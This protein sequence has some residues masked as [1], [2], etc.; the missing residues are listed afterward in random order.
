MFI[1]V[2]VSIR[3]K[4]MLTIKDRRRKILK[5]RPTEVDTIYTL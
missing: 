2:T 4:N 3:L 5:P 1:Q